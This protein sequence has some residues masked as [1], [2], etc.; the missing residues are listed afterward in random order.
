[1]SLILQIDTASDNAHVSLA[2]NGQLLHWLSSESQKEHA[3]FLQAAIQQLIKSVDI[4][5]KEVDA[6]AVTAGPGSYTGLR[7]GMASAKGLCYAL[8]KPL[9]T[10]G[11]LEV[12]TASAL[13][14]FPGDHEDLLYCPMIDARRM[15]IFTAI[16]KHDLSIV[17]K[18]CAMILDELS[19]ENELKNNRIVFFGSG[20]DKWKLICPDSYRDEH[21]IFKTVSISPKSFGTAAY[22]LFSEKKFTELAYSVPVYLKEFQTVIKS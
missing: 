20:S 22:A 17:L 9:I 18:P 4:N 11:T 6:V 3:A 8:K 7:V 12:L 5:I 1:M 10:I 16:Y 21:A 14:L 13:Q 15:E 19:F 2:K